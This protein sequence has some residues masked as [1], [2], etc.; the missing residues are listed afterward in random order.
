LDDTLFGPEHAPEQSA[1]EV[2]HGV[3][4]RTD[5]PQAPSDFLPPVGALVLD[6]DLYRT[7][8][9]LPLPGPGVPVKAREVTTWPFNPPITWRVRE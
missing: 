4:I 5:F 1:A 6:D 2:D 8:P 3:E 9:F 7:P